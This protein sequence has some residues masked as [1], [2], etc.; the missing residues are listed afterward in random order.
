MEF[1]LSFFS[2]TAAPFHDSKYELLLEC[3]KFADRNGFLAVWIP[4]RHFHRFGG[5]YPNPSLTGVLLATSTR[6][7]RIRAG[8][9]VL[10]LHH[11]IR[12]AEE[13]SVVDNLSKG[14]VDLSFATGWSPT[15][16]ILEPQSYADRIDLTFSGIETVRKLWR[17]EP[18]TGPNGLGETTSVQVHPLPMQEELNVWSTCSGRAERFIRSGKA[19]YNVLTALV[20][21]PLDRLARRIKEYREARKNQGHD[22]QSG[23]VTLMLHSFLGDSTDQVRNLVREPMMKY[24]QSSVNLRKQSGENLE[25]LEQRPDALEFAFRRYFATAS[26]FGTVDTCSKTVEKLKQIGVNEIACLVDF[27]VDSSLVL[28][29]LEYLNR[30]RMRHD[31]ESLPSSDHPKSVLKREMGGVEP[32]DSSG[33]TYQTESSTSN[34]PRRTASP[35]DN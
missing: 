19:G 11:P 6:H 29:N 32:P 14:R 15:D 33:G 2:S 5:I 16:F 4:E 22:A 35:S 8:S 10:P 18:F 31:D 9:V 24:L 28:Q 21:Q 26:L 20:L 12:I 3:S 34:S 23:K 1:S 30:L 7:I 17:G 25:K 27:G 13:W